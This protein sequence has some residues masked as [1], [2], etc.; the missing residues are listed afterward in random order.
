M[1]IVFTGDVF[2][3]GDLLNKSA[4]SII[5]SNTFENAD[6][7]IVNLEQPISDNECIADK[8]TL[9]TGSSAIEK[10]KQLNTVAVNLAHNHIQ[11]KENDG[12]I[13]TIEHLDAFNIGHFGAGKNIRDA[14][15]PYW[16][17]DKTCI[18]GYCE[19]GRPYLKQIQVA[20]DVEPGVN[21]LRYDSI[22]KDLN[23]LPEGTKAFLY[24]HWGR[25]HVW[26]PPR[27]DIELAK[28]LLKDERVLLIIGMHCHRIQG[29]IE[30]NG[31]RAYMSLGNFLF[32]NF[33]IKPPTQITYPETLPEKYMTT[34]QYH[35]VS[36]LTYKKW[37]IVNRVSL[38]LE[39]NTE[40]QSVTH[41]P[42][43]QD[44][45]KP[46]VKEVT[47]LSR[48]LVLS[49]VKMLSLFYQ[50]PTKI[51]NP[52]EQLSTFIVYMLWILQ[53]YIFQIKQYGLKYSMKK[54]TILLKK[55]IQNLKINFSS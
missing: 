53:I 30:H 10:L 5:T 49:L 4:E 43:I 48:K 31:K 17:D 51:Y 28:E 42:V 44:D 1:K 14:K 40:T 36:Q 24:F 33:F 18:L 47:G 50:L 34:R 20:T 32:P 11:D 9:H 52:V 21:P 19:F 15:N 45:D 2:L 38:I 54:F 39:Y 3:G 46:R 29:Y 27:G 25:E 8:C 35:S 7:I 16:I 12:I 6:K 22:I 13:E 37:R 26:F 55:T 23:K 41:I